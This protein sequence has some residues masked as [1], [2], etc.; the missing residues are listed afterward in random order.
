[1]TREASRT[2]PAQNASR[3]TTKN[4]REKT[5]LTAAKISKATKRNYKPPPG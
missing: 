2:T 1:M 3:L 4:Q 5:S